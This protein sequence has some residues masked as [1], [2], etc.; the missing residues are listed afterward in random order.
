MTYANI[1]L[2]I[3]LDDL[4]CQRKAFRVAWHM[5]QSEGA[6]LH[7]MTVV[8][9][10]HAI[11]GYFPPDFEEKATEAARQE[12]DAFVD[13]EAPGVGEGIE[14]RVAIG[15]IHR[16]ILRCAAESKADLIVMAAHHP[17]V[18]DVLMSP[19]SVHIVT[20]AIQ[21]VMIVRN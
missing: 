15:S 9:K 6:S 12:L 10:S 14:R 16:E 8:P 11:R 1:L 2:P 19:H 4:D 5:A 3:D 21:S 13:S 20:H 18:R 7:A 17:T